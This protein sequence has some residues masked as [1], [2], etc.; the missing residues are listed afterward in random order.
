MARQPKTRVEA[1]P[2]ATFGDPDQLRCHELFRHNFRRGSQERLPLDCRITGNSA[3]NNGAGVLFGWLYNCALTENF[4]RWKWWRRFK[5]ILNNCTVAG[6]SAYYGGGANASA[7]TNC[8]VYF[9][10]ASS[11]PNHLTCVFDHSCTTPLPPDGAG[12]LSGAPLFVNTNGWSDLHL[13]YGSPGIDAGTDLSAV[14]T[15]GLDGNPRPL[16]GNG[17]GSPPSTWAPTN[18]A[19]FMF[20]PGAPRRLHLTRIGLSRAHHPGRRGCR[21]RGAGHPGYQRRLC[22]RRPRCRPGGR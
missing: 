15:T 13:R 10:N 4:S 17:D 9:N 5:G 12:N 1:A 14:L 18:P 11:G 20:P 16:D 19:C 21:R 8:I 7:L 3:Y 22:R 2:G 6:N